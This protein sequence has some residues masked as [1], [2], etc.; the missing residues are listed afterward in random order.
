[1]K[2]NQPDRGSVFSAFLGTSFSSALVTALTF[3]SGVLIARTLGPEG[4]ADYGMLLL[5]AQ[6]AA[7][8]GCL[9]FFDAAVVHI[10]RQI[11]SAIDVLPTMVASA[12][13]I[14]VFAT[15]V[16]VLAVNILQISLPGVSH[17]FLLAICFLII[18]TLLLIQCFSALERSDL[19]FYMINVERVGSPAVFSLSIASTWQYFG[20]SLTAAVAVCLFV[21]SKFPAIFAW[22]YRYRMYLVGPVAKDF[23]NKT[24]RTGLNLHVAV[25]LGAVASQLDRFFAAASWP[26]DLLGLYFVA[27]SAIGAGY[28]VVTTALNTVL[29]PY[30]A[31][32]EAAN[33]S[34]KISQIIRLTFILTS[35]TVL[36]GW[37]IIPYALPLLYGVA[38]VQAVDMALWLLLALAVLPLKAIVLETGRSL[39]KGRPSVEMTIVLIGTM[40]LGY[41]LTGFTTPEM[42]I[43]FFGLSNIFSTISGMRHMLADGDIR[44]NLTLLP[45]INDLRFLMQIVL[46]VAK[47]KKKQSIEVKK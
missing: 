36:I 30:L 40:I 4:R 29:L 33:R 2:P 13:I 31:G 17:E 15:G 9:S 27:F 26:K 20:T 3:L 37:L 21:F 44:L 25:A 46:K 16:T 7:S 32:L 10:Q 34:N 11:G 1:M 6:T 23:A 35:V 38:Y 45:G 24:L 5:I 14:T 19:N 39:G 8:I 42:L 43:L 47:G 18:A 41:L 28:S 22:L 12:L